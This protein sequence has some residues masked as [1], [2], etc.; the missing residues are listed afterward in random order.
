MVKIP[1]IATRATVAVIVYK[2]EYSYL[3]YQADM[4]LK[5]VQRKRRL[6]RSQSRP[7]ALLFGVLGSPVGSL[8]PADSP[9]CVVLFSENV[10]RCWWT[11][12][13]TTQLLK[14]PQLCKVCAS[15]CNTCPLK[16]RRTILLSDNST[17]KCLLEQNKFSTSWVRLDKIP[18][19]IP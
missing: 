10:P 18:F 15:L 3:K 19:K 14:K 2:W 17:S 13:W 1:V 11:R 6:P 9:E 7:G 5:L 8:A 12:Q 4:R 16:I